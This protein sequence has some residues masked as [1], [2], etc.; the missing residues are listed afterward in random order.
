MSGEQRMERARDE[1][2]DALAIVAQ[3]LQSDEVQGPAVIPFIRISQTLRRANDLL[4]TSS[5][6]V[7]PF[8]SPG[9]SVKV[10]EAVS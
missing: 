10:P 6:D 2:L 8:P 5:A 1:V 4:R 3:A 9:F 7:V